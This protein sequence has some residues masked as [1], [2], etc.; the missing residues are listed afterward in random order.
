MNMLITGGAG[1]IGTHTII[2]LEAAGHNCV[3]AD[4]F[5][6][7]SPE[8]IRRVERILGHTVKTYQA[9]VC[10]KS[11]VE[12]IFRENRIDAVIHCAGLKA[13]GESVFIP[14]DYYRNNIDSTLTLLEVM[15]TNHVKRI[16]FSSSATVYGSPDSV[17]LNETMACKPCTNPYGWTKYMIE[18]ILESVYT[19]DPEWSV[20]LLR[21]FNPTGA[22]ESGI[23]GENPN[24]IPNNLMPNITRSVIT[25]HALQVNGNDYLTADGTCVRDYI[26][27]MDLA[28]GHV[29]AC[30]Y[31]QQHQGVEIINL[32]TGTG[33]SVMDL[34]L[35]FET[36]NRV[37]VPYVLAPRRPGDVDETYA[38]PRKAY[39]L[40]G[41]QSSKSLMDMCRDAWRFQTQNPEGY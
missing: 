29:N 6:N 8:A 16:V 26:H 36:A 9:N 3:I 21:Y 17:P 18:R 13:V 30:E 25:G 14:L 1:Y 19:A 15:R 31:A 38:D 7:S 12:S 40:L 23:I 34:I 35:A 27:V 39:Q 22:H 11:A 5:S 28:R 37:H 20:I 33:Y 41:W 2:A 10:H 4:N 32:G 24:G